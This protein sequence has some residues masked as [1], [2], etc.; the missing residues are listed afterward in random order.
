MS[1]KPDGETAFAI[2]LAA[3][4]KTLRQLPKPGGI[5]DQ[6]SYYMLLIKLALEAFNEKDE[7]EIAEAKAKAKTSGH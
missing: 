2:E 3:L 5:L 6:D 1:A 7:R 4:C